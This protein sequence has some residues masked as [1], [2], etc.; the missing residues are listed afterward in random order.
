[1]WAC[2]SSPCPPSLPSPLPGPLQKLAPCVLLCWQAGGAPL[3]APALLGPTGPSGPSTG[4]FLMQFVVVV[5]F[6][7]AA[8]PVGS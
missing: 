4:V 8:Q 3:P 7:Y 5:M 1:M 2:W 6:G